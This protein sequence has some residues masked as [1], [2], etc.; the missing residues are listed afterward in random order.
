M[1]CCDEKRNLVDKHD[2]HREHNLLVSF[3]DVGQ[4]AVDGHAS[5][6]FQCTQIWT[7]DTLFTESALIRVKDCLAGEDLSH[8]GGLAP[9]KVGGDPGG[10]IAMEDSG[11]TETACCGLLVCIR[12]ALQDEAMALG[13][14]KAW[15]TC[16]QTL[17]KA[18]FSLDVRKK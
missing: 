17:E 5:L 10:V 4:H 18:K 2:I 7:Q 15:R 8:I 1:R 12:E 11:T 14:G 13:E 16:L 3:Q 9:V 6:A